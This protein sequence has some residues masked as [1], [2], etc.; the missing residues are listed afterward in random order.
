MPI[1]T[2]WLFACTFLVIAFFGTT[3][4]MVMAARR[5]RR[6]RRRIIR[7][8]LVSGPLTG[9]EIARVARVGR[10]IVYVYLTQLEED[11]VVVSKPLPLRHGDQFDVPRRIYSLKEPWKH[12]AT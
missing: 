9:L 1:E 3:H 6:N 10:G 7:T 4:L 2:I 5:N 8:L 12:A 11:G